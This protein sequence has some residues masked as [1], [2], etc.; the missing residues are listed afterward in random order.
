[1]S[2]VIYMLPIT[3]LAD[4]SLIQSSSLE[5]FSN[6]SSFRLAISNHKE[7]QQVAQAQLSLP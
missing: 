3:N 6:T 7:C 4:Q 2:F 1:M 5:S